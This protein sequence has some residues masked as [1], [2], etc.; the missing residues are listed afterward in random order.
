METNHEVPRGSWPPTGRALS[1]WIVVAL[2]VGVALVFGTARLSGI[3]L[4]RPD[5]QR[6]QASVRIW[7]SLDTL[8]AGRTE[9]HVSL[10]EVASGPGVIGIG[11]LS[12]LRGEIAIVRGEPWLSYALPGGGVRVER[13]GV[14]DEQATFLAVADVPAWQSQSLDSAVAFEALAGELERRAW[15]AGLDTSEPIP[16]LIEGALSSIELN[17]VNGPALGNQTPT[18]ERMADVAIRAAVPAAEGTVVGFL[19]SRGGDRL[20]HRGKR[21]HLHV[22]LP[23]T[24]HVGHLDSV[25]VGEGSVLRLPRAVK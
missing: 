7:S 16:V 2:L 4:M 22:V 11:S 6:A 10:S 19:A 8:K 12:G 25:V 15:Q 17:V 14:R 18:D 24:G 5:A 3:S 21:V 9:A 1:S 13:P 23:A 20:I